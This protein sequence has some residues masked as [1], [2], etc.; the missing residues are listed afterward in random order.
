MAPFSTLRVVDLSP[1]RVG[2]QISQL[3]ADYGADVV[4]V[5]P[6]GGSDVRRHPAFPFWG[7]GKR[8]IA[9]D[10]HDEA[11]RDVVRSLARGADVVIESM[12]P[13]A[14]ERLGLGY[15]ELSADNPGLVLTSVSGFG[16][17]GPLAGIPGWEGLVLAKMG[18]FRSFRRMSRTPERPP[19]L[20]APFA[21][22]AASQ[23]ALHGTLAALHER[24]RTGLGQRV[25]TNLV[26]AFTTLDTWSTTEHSITSRWPGAYTPY[27]A[28]DEQGRPMSPLS[29]MLLVA[30]A[31]TGTWLQFASVG[32]HL[33]TATMEALGLSWMLTDPEWKGIPAFEDPDV[34][35]AAWTKLLEAASSRS[36]E[37]WEAAFEADHDV[38]AEQFRAG[39]SILDHPQLVHDGMVVE[40]ADAERGVVRQPASIVGA[41]GT[42]ARLDASA[43]RLDEHG[44]DIRSAAAALGSAP[45]VSS[46]AVPAEGTLPL[47]GVTILELAVLFAAPQGPAM[48]T[49]LGARVIK[50]ERLEGDPI[51]T[52]ISFPESGGVRV[53]QGKESICV[54]LSTPEGI[55]IVHAIATDADV[56]MQGF[57]AGVAERLGLD[58]T[59]IRALNPDVIYVNAPGYGVDGPYGDRP[60]FAPSI[61]AAVG[62]PLTNLGA[63]MPTGADLTMAQVQDGA[64]RLSAAGTH[65]SAQADGVAALGVAT[66]ILF[67]LLAR[68]LGADGQ[69][70][71]TSMVNTGAHLMSAQAVDWEGSPGEA[72]VD[73]DLRGL[74]ARYRV[75]DAA[76]G[77]VFLAAPTDRDWERLVAALAGEIDLGGDERFVD[78]DAR[79]AA[80]AALADVLAEVFLR[81]RADDW[82]RDLLA[83]GVGCVAVDTR[84]SDAFLLDDEVGRESGYVVDTVHPTFDE[85]PRVAPYLTFSRSST[86]A[87]PGVLAGQHT[88]EILAQLGRDAAAIAEL[89]DRHI[90]A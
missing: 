71:F 34:F 61:A 73:A 56:V 53:M 7:R 1:T 39:T 12:R 89:R 27:D 49:D 6:P 65:A 18:A 17:R 87:L 25:E 60:A 50:V 54:D 90:V 77:Y 88:D 84:G 82:E 14:I 58:D 41:A 31:S 21:S 8:S 68:D 86:R 26:Q 19:F 66:A 72:S 35:L 79:R 20:T 62:I 4:M 48:L 15:D 81:R 83:A 30:P 74:G 3:F 76:D 10:L 85:F 43:P 28:Y 55:A 63:S 70:L 13:G 33:F 38:F 42:P 46:P 52:I 57:R 51:R 37:E 78:A 22:F 16:R 67:G 36:L 47:D 5:E 9:L 32:P 40:L 23:V 24:V 44:S 59:T 11:D 29:L 80:D 45:A 64:R 69:E 75:Y 2:A